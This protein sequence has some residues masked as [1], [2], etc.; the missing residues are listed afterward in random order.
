[1]SGLE[2]PETS[3]GQSF[4]GVAKVQRS[5]GSTRVTIPADAAENLGLEKG[6]RLVFRSND[7]DEVVVGKASELF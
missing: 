4:L 7:G 6:D 3:D 5:T 1:M 2:A